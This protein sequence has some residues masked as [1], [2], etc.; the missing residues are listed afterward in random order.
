MKKYNDYI[1]KDSSFDKITWLGIF[2]LII[3]MA[4][5]FGFVYE[6]IFY[7]FNGGMDKF[8][9]RG[10]NFLPWI[11]IYAIGAIAIYYLTYK[12][13]TNIYRPLLLLHQ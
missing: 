13:R 11:N 6:F 4:G 12:K 10:G 7:Y 9:W 8:Y 2:C 1:N 3:V 5:I